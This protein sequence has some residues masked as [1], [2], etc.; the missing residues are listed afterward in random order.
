[1]TEASIDYGQAEIAAFNQAAGAGIIQFDP[2]AV[3]EAIG[4]YDQ[5][6]SGL[7]VIRQRLSDA[8]RAV[9]FGG[10]DSARELQQG[11]SNKAAQG[12]EAVDKLIEGAMRLQEA[13]MR[14]GNMVEEADVRNADILRFI[15]ESAGER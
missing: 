9:G 4:L 5:M 7:Y 15:A 11:F 8:V 10:F 2:V 3:R 13:Y 12:I 1:M 6:I 14:T